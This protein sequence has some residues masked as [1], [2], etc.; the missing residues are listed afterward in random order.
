M[1]EINCFEGMFYRK[2]DAHAKG[3]EKREEIRVL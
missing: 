3:R 1:K 2:I